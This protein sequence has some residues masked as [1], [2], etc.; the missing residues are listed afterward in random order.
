MAFRVTMPFST[1]NGSFR[2]L[3]YRIPAAAPESTGDLAA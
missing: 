1:G 2:N 3:E